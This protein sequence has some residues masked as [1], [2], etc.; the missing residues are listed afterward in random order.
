MKTVLFI[1]K[2]EKG[3]WPS[4]L[5]YDFLLDEFRKEGLFEVCEWHSEQRS[6][7]EAIP[8]IAGIIAPNDQWQAVVVTDL[9]QTEAE[10]RDDAHFDNPFDFRDRYQCDPSEALGESEHAVVRLTQMLGGFPEKMRVKWPDKIDTPFAEL[11]DYGVMHALPED[12]YDLVE[13]YRL[14]LPKPIR[15]ICVTP[16]DVDEAFFDTRVK[17]LSELDLGDEADFWQRNDYPSIARFVVCDRMAP[18]KEAPQPEE[19][20]WDVMPF[21]QEEV[22]GPLGRSEWFNFWICVLTL[23]TSTVEASDLR[24]FKVYGMSVDIDERQL[25]TMFAQRR[26]QWVAARDVIEAC[27]KGDA[28]RLRASEYVMTPLPDTNVIIPVTF[29]QVDTQRLY[30]DPSEVRLIKDRPE[31]DLRV[32]FG[33]RS[34][35]MD[36]FRELLRAPR[37]ALRNAA[38][39]FRD[40][41]PIPEEELEYCILNEYQ[42]DK[43]TDDLRGQEYDLARSVDKPPFRMESYGDKLEECDVAVKEQIKL[44]PVFKQVIWCFVVAFVGTLIGFVPYIAGTSHEKLQFSGEALLLALACCLVLFVVG[45]VVLLIMRNDVRKRYLAHD[46]LM[47]AITAFLSGEATRLEEKVSSYAVFRKRWQIMDRQMHLDMPTKMV[48]ELGYQSALLKT[49]I[50]DI[51]EIARNCE[52]AMSDCVLDYDVTWETVS[53][54]LKED[55]F[56]NLCDVQR[57]AYEDSEL[58]YASRT[59]SDLPY[60]FIR[61]A[62]LEELDLE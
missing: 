32:W 4:F 39:K 10:L 59:F 6:V 40:T 36:E 15:V 60:S 3:L 37:R 52:V 2:R 51:D 12:A 5:K 22:R 28:N 46:E 21:A 19:K 41:K 16:R 58:R 17:E 38:A 27:C 55:S 7:S 43:L 54:W 57:S 34:R 8:E 50:R 35:I 30:T 56:F 53:E 9:R 26:A 23:M 44:R 13:R 18:A 1:D 47:N 25:T 20:P 61:K 42:K 11:K 45:M 48:R 33:Q 24:A 31:K 29:D 14:G 49:R 62:S